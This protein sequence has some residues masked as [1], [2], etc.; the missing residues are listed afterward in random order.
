VAGTQIPTVSLARFIVD[1]LFARL[2][3]ALFSGTPKFAD[4]NSRPKNLLER[5]R[6]DL[7]HRRFRIEGERAKPEWLDMQLPLLELRSRATKSSRLGSKSKIQLYA[8]DAAQAAVV[9]GLRCLPKLDERG[10]AKLLVLLAGLAGEKLSG[11]V[12]LE[13]PE[14]V[15]TLVLI[16]SSAGARVARLP[17]VQRALRSNDFCLHRLYEEVVE[18]RDEHAALI[19]AQISDERVGKAWSGELGVLLVELE[20]NRYACRVLQGAVKKMLSKLA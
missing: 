20:R 6:L 5:A 14:V 18:R 1:I 4:S 11:L 15:L 10:D 9:D 16:D 13:E 17:E 3:L 2:S 19:L 8:S 7:V 12:V